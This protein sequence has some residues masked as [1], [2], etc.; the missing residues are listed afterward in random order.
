[1]NSVSTGMQSNIVSGEVLHKVQLQVLS[2][3]AHA[4][5]KTMGPAGSN[6]LI[7]KGMSSDMLI[8]DYTK[9]G[10]Q[11]IKHIKYAGPLEMSIQTEIEQITRSIEKL[12]GDGT[13]T[14]VVMSYYIFEQIFNDEEIDI[15]K[16]PFEIIRQFKAAVELIKARIM[17]RKRECTLED[18]GKISYISTNGNAELAAELQDVY[19]EYGMNVFIDVGT[20]V[21]ENSY[22]KCHDGLVLDVGYSSNVYINTQMGVSRINN[23]R[24]YTFQDSIDTP[25]M[26]AMFETILN[27]NIIQHMNDRKY[28][29]TVIIAPRISRDMSGLLRQLLGYLGQFTAEAATQKPPVLIITNIDGIS[30][31]FID[32]I[33]QLCGCKM[34]AKYI[35]PAIRKEHQEKGLA[36]T[37][38]NICDEWYGEAEAVEADSVTSKFINP[39]KMFVLDEEGMIEVDEAGDPVH[40]NEYNAIIDFISAEINRLTTTGEHS[41]A[42]GSLKEQLNAL[43]ANMVEYLVGGLAVSDRNSAKDLVEDAVLNCRSAAKNGVGFGASY[44]GYLATSIELDRVYK[45]D[46]AEN[47]AIRSYFKIILRAYERFMTDLYSTAMEPQQAEQVVATIRS[48]ARN[49]ASYGIGTPSSA[50]G[51]MN[52]TSGERDGSVLTSIMTDGTVLDVI[53]KIIM[54]MVTSNQAVLQA[55]NLNTYS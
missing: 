43:K 8:A 32:H 24:I 4:I 2:D 1:M 11:L 36:P 21:D 31:N 52:I 49:Y 27:N 29:P 33:S 14:A 19:R 38:D 35:D 37:L 28:V 53:S 9:D 39:S 41:G 7:L 5:M 51:P 55:P 15:N 23:P 17:E 6:T 20:S 12:V 18:I 40:S 10:N 45:S 47:L 13:S 30:V 34:I 42:I 46:D 54:I 50:N 22:I 26:C 44:E 25:E 3:L 16:N 48:E